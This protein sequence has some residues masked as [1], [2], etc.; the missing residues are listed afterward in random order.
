MRPGVVVLFQKKENGQANAT[1]QGRLLGIF[2]LINKP[3]MAI[4][5]G[6]AI[7]QQ[8]LNITIN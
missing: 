1:T 5:T 8:I 7:S 4:I 6:N 3:I 2:R